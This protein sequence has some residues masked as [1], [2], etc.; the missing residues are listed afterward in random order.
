MYNTTK[1]ILSLLLALTMAL[2][3]CTGAL[4]AETSVQD[5]AALSSSGEAVADTSAEQEQTDASEQADASQSAEEAEQEDVPGDESAPEESEQAD[6]SEPEPEEE[7]PESSAQEDAP[8]EADASAGADSSSPEPEPQAVEPEEAEEAQEAEDGTVSVQEENPYTLNIVETVKLEKEYDD[9]FTFTEAK[10]GYVVAQIQDQVPTSTVVARGKDTKVKDKAVVRLSGDANAVAVGVGTAT[11][12][13]VKSEDLAEAK[14]LLSSESG[15]A[16][17]SVD[18]VQVDLVVRPAPLTILFLAGQSN[19]EGYG[20]Y[21]GSGKKDGR[22]YQHPEQSIVCPEGEV[23]STYAPGDTAYSSGRANSIGG[24]VKF[25]S[26]CSVGKAKHFVAESLTSDKSV[27]GRDL[28]YP[29]NQLT[30]KGTGKNGPD[31]GLAYEWNRL[32]GEKVWTVN[33]ARGGSSIK[34][35]V[36]GKGCYDRAKAVFG[37]ALQVYNAEIEA[38]HYTQA[39]KLCFWLQGESDAGAMKTSEY[40]SKFKLM[41]KNLKAVTGFERM[42]LISVRG[43]NSGASA[44][45]YRSSDDVVMSNPRIIQTYMTNTKSFTDVCI[46]SDVNERW[47]TN[48]G[49][50]TY[51]QKAYGSALSYK[52]HGKTP[53]LPTKVSQVHNDIHYMQV[54]HNENGLTAARGMYKWMTGTAKATGVKW[55]NAAGKA[56]S[57]VSVAKGKSVL[58][59]PCVVDV[60]ASK[61]VKWKLSSGLSYNS[62]SGKL[63][64]TKPGVQTFTALDADGKVLSTLYVNKTDDLTAPA[65]KSASNVKGK[66]IAVAWSKSASAAG[67]QVQYALNAKFTGAKSANVKGAANVKTTLTK[68]AKKTY[69]V[70]VRAYK[71]GAKTTYSS[72]SSTRKV[73]VSK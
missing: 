31:S 14:I 43:L 73:K 60:A 28:V 13:M 20:S 26:S 22:Y 50:K 3:L 25:A 59:S 57:S 4:A 18:A 66:K 70:R 16:T 61:G 46:V 5:E 27:S 32:T 36:P 72:W 40:L 56:V 42:G 21:P 68:L 54:G 41:R 47:V 69:Y 8:Q 1:R 11:A 51:F 15:N 17:R 19:M 37:Y 23:Y 62:K 6:A 9:R 2:S 45:S 71:T 65:L 63:K 53:A 38:G 35:W 12:V 67:Y 49:V 44:S 7:A 58:V 34:L 52:T 64:V 10:K 30:A 24:N 29:L 39:H 33:S 48:N 55:R